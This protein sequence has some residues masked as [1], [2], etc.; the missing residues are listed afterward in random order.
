M[1]PFKLK[2]SGSCG[3]PTMN[4]RAY[5]K[6]AAREMGLADLDPVELQKG[7]GSSDLKRGRRESRVGGWIARNLRH[8][9]PAETADRR[10]RSEQFLKQPDLVFPAE[11]EPQAK[12]TNQ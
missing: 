7:S 3:V 1:A 8:L 12:S 10:Q 6:N 4:G 2:S 9:T 5:F 11:E